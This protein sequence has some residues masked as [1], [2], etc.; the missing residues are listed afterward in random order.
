[1]ASIWSVGSFRR[2]LEPWAAQPAGSTR[3]TRLARHAA[4]PQHAVEG[5][6]RRVLGR[7]MAPGQG[8][9]IAEQPFAVGQ[10]G[11]PDLV[12]EV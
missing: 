12:V 7:R 4:R 1:M 10:A 2:S 6:L 11:V 8:E 9:R 3:R 5:R